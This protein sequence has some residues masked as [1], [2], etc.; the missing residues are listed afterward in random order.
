VGT[1]LDRA[2]GV[3]LTPKV[4][5]KFPERTTALGPAA[6]AIPT[7]RKAATTNDAVNNALRMG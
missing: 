2:R 1:V 3:E 6:V 4:T 7:Q 5:S